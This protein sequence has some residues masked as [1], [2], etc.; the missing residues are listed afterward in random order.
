MSRKRLYPN[1]PGGL[2]NVTTALAS[3]LTLGNDTITY[4]QIQ[5]VTAQRLLGRQDAASGDIQEIPLSAEMRFDTDND[6]MEIADCGILTQHLKDS[7]VSTAKLLDSNVTTG[8]LDGSSVTTAKIADS[9]VTTAKLDGSSVTTLKIADSAVMTAKISDSQVTYA[10][11]QAVT[12]VRLLG[13]YD[14]SAGV[15]QEVALGAGLSFDSSA[16]TIIS[17]GD[18]TLDDCTILTQ[19]LKDSA[20][21]TVKLLDSAVTAAKIDATA[22][23]TAKINDSAITAAKLDATSVTTAKINANAVTADKLSDSNGLR[24]IM[25]IH[26]SDTTLAV[27]DTAATFFI[28][29]EMDSFDL[30]RA[31]MAAK[32]SSTTGRPTIQLRDVTGSGDMLVNKIIMDTGEKTSYTADTASSVDTTNDTVLTGTEIAI[33]VDS[34][35]TAEDVWV[36]LTFKKP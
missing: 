32:I 14:A 30:I 3:G 23:T 26:V 13:R 18:T 29:A 20:V 2:L 25:M 4:S 6:W 9:N 15:V 24:R 10:K 16:G 34:A 22:V 1:L 17:T 35:G 7:A 11:I 27:G 36:I 5:N 12:A 21:S 33:D 19:H 28:P 31:E 8:K